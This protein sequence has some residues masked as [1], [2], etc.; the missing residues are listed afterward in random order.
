MREND[1][2][3]SSSPSESEPWRS[4]ILVDLR[5]TDNSINLPHNKS[6]GFF[7]SPHLLFWPLF[8][9]LDLAPPPSS[10]TWSVGASRPCE[11]QAQFCGLDRLYKGKLFITIPLSL[12]LVAASDPSMVLVEKLLR[13]LLELLLPILSSVFLA[14]LSLCSSSLYIDAMAKK[15]SKS[16]A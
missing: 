3:P 9:T 13:S 15:N 5:R 6:Q 8:S 1:T 12:L 11:I 14:S 4:I 10:P 7:S 2:F 16:Q